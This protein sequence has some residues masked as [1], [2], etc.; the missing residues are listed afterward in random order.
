MPAVTTPTGHCTPNGSRWRDAG[1]RRTS[2][3]A[4]MSA[5][6]TMPGPVDAG[7]PPG[8]LRGGERDERHRPADRDRGRGRAARRRR[9]RAAR[10]RPGATPSAGRG[11]VAHLDELQ[12]AGQRRARS[13]SSTTSTTATVATSL[14]AAGREAAVEP[15]GDG[16]RVLAAGP[17]DRELHE[18]ERHRADADADHH[19][20]VRRREPAPGAE[21]H[22]RADRDHRAD[23]RTD[24]RRH[25][26]G[27]HERRRRSARRRAGAEADDV[28]AAERVAGDALEDRAGDA[29]RRAGAERRPASR[30]SR[31]VNTTQSCARL[32]SPREH[33]AAARRAGRRARRGQRAAR[34]TS[35]ASTRR[36]APHDGD[37]RAATPARRVAPAPGRGSAGRS[38]VDWRRRRRR[39]SQPGP[40]PAH[41]RDEER[42]ADER[43][44]HADHELAGPGDHAADDVGAEQE[45]RAEQR[46]STAAASGSPTR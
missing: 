4:P 27:P 31:L 16:L 45:H 43:R 9:P 8:D 46:R 14:P 18:R 28:R 23:E 24:G 44:H 26:A 38:A 19:H 29:E 22:D 39:R 32:P 33:G 12:A 41:G 7:Q 10:V 15:R 5:A 25:D 2:S 40:P 17:G 35:T 34:A 21:Q 36:R 1:R 20:P 3:G 37:D 6:A 30:G 42:R 13:G 11:V